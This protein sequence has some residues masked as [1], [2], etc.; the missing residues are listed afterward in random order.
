MSDD[1]NAD[2]EDVARLTAA[3]DEL[4]QARQRADEAATQQQLR[5]DVDALTQ[6]WLDMAE[7]IGRSQDEI[8]EMEIQRLRDRGADPDEV[9][10]AVQALA[11]V[12]AAR[13]RADAEAVRQGLK[14]NKERYADELTELQKMLDA[15][16]LSDAEYEKAR[17]KLREKHGIGQDVVEQRL[18]VSGTFSSARLG[19]QFASMN[20]E[21]EQL[22]V[23]K[24][25]AKGIHTVNRNLREKRMSV[26]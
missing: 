15:K 14:T 6:S 22:A 12:R 26:T 13:L 21:K 17:E 24:D 10:A 18:A 8:E 3:Y 4:T 19:G 2:A 9:D 7:T 1:P 16:L 23:Q 5:E 20:V 11:K 25:I